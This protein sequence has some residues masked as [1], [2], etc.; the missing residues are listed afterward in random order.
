[1]TPAVRLSRS[2][3][4]VTVVQETPRKMTSDESGHPGDENFH[5]W[6]MENGEWRMENGCWR[7]DAGMRIELC[8]PGLDLFY[9]LRQGRKLPL[10]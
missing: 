4:L 8:D 5:D 10:E 6:R 9:P 1:M 2:T 3:H 7:M